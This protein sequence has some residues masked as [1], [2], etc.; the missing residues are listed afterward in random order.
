MPPI[1][2][3][4]VR[5]LEITP[6]AQ[7]LNPLDVVELGTRWGPLASEMAFAACHPTLGA[8]P[9]SALTHVISTSRINFRRRITD[10]RPPSTRAHELIPT[11]M[12]IIKELAMSLNYSVLARS[13]SSAFQNSLFHIPNSHLQLPTRALSPQS[14]I[15][16]ANNTGAC[17]AAIT[18][19]AWTQ[20]N[21]ENP[22]RERF[23]PKFKKIACPC[24]AFANANN[25][26]YPNKC[27]CNHDN[28]HHG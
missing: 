23:N 11:K 24:R 3:C 16:P 7:L 27:T 8:G 18:N 12:S 25:R 15:M 22:G 10:G 20:W 4:S 1:Q 9:W 14:T 28:K 2:A 26:N 17:T 13:S 5:T 21:N 6:Y 19:P